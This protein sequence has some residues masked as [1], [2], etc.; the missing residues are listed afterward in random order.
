MRTGNLRMIE[1]AVRT[2]VCGTVLMLL[3]LPGNSAA[4]NP[5]GWAG[6]SMAIPPA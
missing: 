3:A 6:C 5:P 2:A 1:K 4:A